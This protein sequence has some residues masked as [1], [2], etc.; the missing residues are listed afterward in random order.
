MKI[1][2]ICFYGPESTGKSS[3]AIRMAEVFHTTFVPEVARE[4]LVKNDFSIEEIIQIGE[5]QTERILKKEKTATRL[6][7]C[8]TD[9]I[10]TQIYADYYLGVVPPILYE[11]EQKVSYDLYFLFD[12]D[13]PWVADGLRDIPHKREE[14][15]AIFKTALDQRNIPYVVVRGDY[16]TREAIVKREIEKL[17]R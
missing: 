12:V 11:L 15:F 13:V 5:R 10:T 8:D 3:M 4:M 16:Q 6:L 17:L 1:K 14:M 2:K 9:L 7:M